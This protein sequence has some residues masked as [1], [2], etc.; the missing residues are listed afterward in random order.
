MDESRY[1]TGMRVRREVHGDA[2]VDQAEARQT[3]FDADFQRFITEVAWGTLWARPN[4]D[5]RTR[6]LLTIAILAALGRH[7]EL[8]L[9]VRSSQNTGATTEEIAET[10]LHVAVYA[11]IPA[12]NAA[13]TLSKRIL[14]AT[15]N[16]ASDKAN[17]KQT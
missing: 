8:E 11:G 13:F 16:D 17:A 10:L 14:T 7:E 1:E 9:H 4:L 15:S 5:R 6:S 3:T 12:A 2:W